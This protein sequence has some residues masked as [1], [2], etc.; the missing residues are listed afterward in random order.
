MRHAYI[1]PLDGGSGRGESISYIPNY[2]DIICI[3][4]CLSDSYMF[5]DDKV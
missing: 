4:Q 2:E 3:L 1:G 5:N